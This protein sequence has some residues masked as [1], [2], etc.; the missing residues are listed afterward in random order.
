MMAG[1]TMVAPVAD[2]E[3]ARFA[4]VEAAWC[5][6]LDLKVEAAKARD[7]PQ[8]RVA[9]GDQLIAFSPGF[10]RPT[11]NRVPSPPLSLWSTVAGDSV[12]VIP[13]LLRM[14]FD[15][16]AVDSSPTILL[17]RRHRLDA[18]ILCRLCET[19]LAR[20]STAGYVELALLLASFV[21]NIILKPFPC[22][23]GINWLSRPF[24]MTAL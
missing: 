12:T 23:P 4:G 3:L 24:W 21:G 14:F 15:P 5:E 18:L 10:F 19:L 16:F 13:V 9:F 7:Y 11:V 20:C 22:R 1:S 2:R 17:R 8:D 6:H